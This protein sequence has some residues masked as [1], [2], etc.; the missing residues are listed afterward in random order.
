MLSK[1][2]KII[3]VGTRA[4]LMSEH[5]YARLWLTLKAMNIPRQKILDE[6]ADAFR[7]C[8]AYII[9]PSGEPYRIPFVD[10]VFDEDNRWYDYYLR[11]NPCGTKPFTMS[12]K[13]ERIQV[14]DLFLKIKYPL[15]HEKICK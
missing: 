9:Y 15:I 7:D 3:K 13:L 14:L 6:V 11:S 10:D 2:K 4:E 12:R 8:D 5:R 1:P